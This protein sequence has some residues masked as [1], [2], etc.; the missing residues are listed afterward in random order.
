MHLIFKFI[1]EK[2]FRIVE[3]LLLVSNQTILSYRPDTQG[4]LTVYNGNIES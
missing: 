2:K 4:L 3:I 1:L